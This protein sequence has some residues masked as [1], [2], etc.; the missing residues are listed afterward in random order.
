MAL[1]GCAAPS[2]EIA[3]DVR[4]PAGT[5][6]HGGEIVVGIAQ[7]LDASLDPH[8]MLTAGGTAG[9]RQVL[10]NVFEGLVRPTPGGELIPAVAESFT[11]DDTQ[12][13]FRL[14]TGVRFHNGGLVTA[15]DVVY[16]IQ[17][18]AN[19]SSPSTFVTALSV[20]TNV[21][22]IDERTVI[23]EIEAP[24]NEFL[25]H[26]TVAIIP[27]GYD[28]QARHPIGTGPFRFVSF[29]NQEYLTLE[30]F[31]DYWGTPAYLDRVT[32]HVYGSVET[33]I[34]AMNAGSIDIASHFTVD[35]IRQL[36]DDFYYVEGSMNLVQ[37]LF[38]N[39]AV[40]PLDDIRV[41]QALNYAIDVQQIM[42]ILADGRGTPIGSGLHP[43]LTRFFNA[44]VV[45][46]YPHNTERAME[47][48]AEAGHAG[49]FDLNITVPAVYTPHVITAEVIVE[50]LRAVGVR[51]TI[52]QVEWTYW[53]SEVNSG[54]N[55]EATIIG[56][57]ASNLT[58]HTMLE[59]YVT[60][61][62][63]N[64]MNFSSAD[65]DA[66]FQ[67]ARTATDEAE[68]IRLYK[69]LQEILAREAASVFLQDLANLVAINRRLAG[70]Q[71]YSLYVID[72]AS[73]HFVEPNAYV[74]GHDVS[75]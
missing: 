37:G 64:F 58:A 32:F 23:I 70:F 30:R 19:P 66:T 72:L 75:Y 65:F 67:Q 31:E 71:F 74:F 9:T 57:A 22:A 27:M 11:V 45:D 49:G 8:Q 40:A 21:E 73:I 39:N 35:Q 20:I 50:Q 43:G 7:N 47:L 42:A 60:S 18:A 4:P 55:F 1:S 48:L 6:V 46:F 33:A 2:S 15:E 41:R 51:A 56:L 5:P 10:F 36:S 62:R 53:L 26:L 34:M 69:E 28:N 12:Y 25:A 24:D 17:R 54:R 3:G 59:R 38:L 61:N 16:S 29:S 14:R 13:T 63:R 44:D 68:Q 52:N